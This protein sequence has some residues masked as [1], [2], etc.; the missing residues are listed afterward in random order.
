MWYGHEDPR[1]K[2][3]RLPGPLQSNNTGETTAVLVTVQDSNPFDKIEIRSD[4]QYTAEG[5][6]LHLN[7]WQDI[8][9]TGISNCEILKPTG[10]RL[11]NRGEIS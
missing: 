2:A 3:L 7:D 11:Q 6:M 10:A 4:S 8:G 9:W 1:N 5:L